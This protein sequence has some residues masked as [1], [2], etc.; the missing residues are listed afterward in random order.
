MQQN[1]H[2]TSS[3]RQSLHIRVP[4]DIMT[5]GRGYLRYFLQNKL[6]GYTIGRHILWFTRAATR[7]QG[8][9]VTSAT[10][11]VPPTVESNIN[12]NAA[13]VVTPEDVL[14]HLLD[15]GKHA[16]DMDSLV[17]SS[18]KSFARIERWYQ[19]KPL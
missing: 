2:V 3:W 9:T 11:P 4:G 10:Y 14:D 16:V 12:I 15:D 5:T 19:L 7:K 18:Q 6:S 8:Q 17:Q 13:S 1:L